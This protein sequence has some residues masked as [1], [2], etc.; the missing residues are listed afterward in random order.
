MSDDRLI[1][2]ETIKAIVS[3]SISKSM[4]A[5]QRAQLEAQIAPLEK[6]LNKLLE[7]PS[8]NRWAIRELR[9]QLDALWKERDGA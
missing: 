3:D 6:K 9:K 2:D 1:S 8:A 4:D 5:L 7:F